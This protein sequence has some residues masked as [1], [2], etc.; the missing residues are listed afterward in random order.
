MR[1]QYS[2]TKIIILGVVLVIGSAMGLP[3]QTAPPDPQAGAKLTPEQQSQLNRLS[4]LEDQLQ[5]SRA[6]LH[7][8]INEY[9]WESDQADDAREKLVNDR[10]EYRKLRRSL[11][12][13]GVTVPPPSGFSAGGPG[14]PPGRGAGRWARGG[15]GCHHC[16]QCG[17][18]CGGW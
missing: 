11:M 15:H 16:G 1:R 8:T 13:S 12:A 14:N 10:D 5:K 2:W 18:N 7:A 4:Q 17:C 9:G 6:A 3:A